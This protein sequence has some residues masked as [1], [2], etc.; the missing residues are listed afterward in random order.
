MAVGESGTVAARLVA[1]GRVWAAVACVVGVVCLVGVSVA[2]PLNPPAGPVASTPGPEPRTAVN[3][4]NTPGDNDATPSLFKITQPGSY[5]LA[6]NVTGVVGKHG[7]EIASS[8]V[9]L[10]LSGFALLGAVGSLDGV[11]ASTP[12]LGDIQVRNGSIRGWGGS[13][14][15]LLTGNNNNNAA[16]DLRVSGC[17]GAYGI[18]IGRGTVVGCNASG[19]AE[20]GIGASEG[21]SIVRCTAVSNGGRGINTNF[22]VVITECA[23]YDNGGWGISTTGDCVVSDCAATSNDGG[24]IVCG[25]RSRISG[26]TATGNDNYGIQTGVASIV[27][28]CTVSSSRAGDSASGLGILGIGSGVVI[29]GCTVYANPSTGIRLTQRGRV[30]D[31]TVEFNSGVGIEVENDSMVTGCTVT[32]S[33]TLGIV[34]GDDCTITGCTSNRNA[35]SGIRVDADCHVTN[36]TCNDNGLTGTGAAG[37]QTTAAN[38]RVEGNVC[39]NNQKGFDTVAGSTGNLFIRN[40]ASSNVV[41]NYFFVANNRYGPIVDI[42]GATAAVNGNSAASTMTTADP[43]ANIRY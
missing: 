9:T 11:T 2:G 13:G 12:S 36:N 3:A 31:C 32:S 1:I 41:A 29:S 21:S 39:S 7:I 5:Y 10:D 14:L 8:G 4:V 38:N 23:V 24:G 20:D 18:S 25:S 43:H 19:N 33:G 15:E 28:G 37:I 17:L 35:L 42:T 16:H 34:A 22:G 27:I 26:C 6:G 30:I 40:S